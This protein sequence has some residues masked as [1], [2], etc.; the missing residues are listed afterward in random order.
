MLNKRQQST[1][2]STTTTISIHDSTRKRER[3]ERENEKEKFVRGE[4]ERFVKQAI[5][6][7]T[8]IS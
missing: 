3:R 5:N 1:F 6:I 2:L 8:T 7:A 4:R